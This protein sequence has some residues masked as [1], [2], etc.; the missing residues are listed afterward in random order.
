MRHLS[1]VEVLIA[2]APRFSREARVRAV[3]EMCDAAPRIR[4]YSAVTVVN[5]PF[6]L[7]H[8]KVYLG[9]ASNLG[10]TSPSLLLRFKPRED[11]RPPEPQAT[12]QTQHWHWVVVS[13]TPTTTR[14]IV[15]ARFFALQHGSEISDCQ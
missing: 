3:P 9:H 15:D 8:P 2:I 12:R 5:T 6:V 11:A 1:P 10:P 4:S 13:S 14:Q 7:P